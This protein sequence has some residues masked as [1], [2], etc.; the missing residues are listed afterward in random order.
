MVIANDTYLAWLDV[1]S[2]AESHDVT[3]LQIRFD[4]LNLQCQRDIVHTY[5]IVRSGNDLI[6]PASLKLIG[7]ELIS[8]KSN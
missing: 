4:R 2:Y 5:S 3:V 6:N 1:V 8:R 7:L